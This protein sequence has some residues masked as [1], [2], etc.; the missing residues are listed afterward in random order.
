MAGDAL[1]A[2]RA[3]SDTNKPLQKCTAD[4]SSRNEVFELS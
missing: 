3:A 1:Q 2:E 4:M